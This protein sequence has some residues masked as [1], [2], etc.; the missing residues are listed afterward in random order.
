MATVVHT[1]NAFPLAERTLDQHG[2]C[3]QPPFTAIR[4][5][6]S[7]FNIFLLPVYPAALCSSTEAL[8]RAGQSVS[9][10]LYLFP[11]GTYQWTTQIVLIHIAMCSGKKELRKCPAKLGLGNI[12]LN[13]LS[14]HFYISTTVMVN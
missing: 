10:N 11:M 8:L 7:G 9:Q 1:V 6:P 13:Q 14:L 12:I 4:G 2:V 5:G 3:P